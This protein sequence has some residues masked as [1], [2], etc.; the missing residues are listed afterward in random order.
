MSNNGKPFLPLNLYFT[1]LNPLEDSFWR[2]EMKKSAAYLLK[3]AADEGQSVYPQIRYPN[4]SLQDTPLVELFGDNLPA[5]QALKSKVD[6]NRI[7]DLTGGFRI[8]SA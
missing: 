6:P 8:P 2:N 1:W 5:L 4:Y 3:V 7:M